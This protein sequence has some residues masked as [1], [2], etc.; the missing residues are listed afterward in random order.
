MQKKV[1]KRCIQKN[2]VYAKNGMK[3]KVY[4]RR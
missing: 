3:K 4:K 1:K 2:E